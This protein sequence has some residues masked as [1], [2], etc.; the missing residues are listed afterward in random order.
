MAYEEYLSLPD[1]GHLVEWVDGEV[2]FHTPPTPIHQSIILFLSKLLGSYVDQMGIGTIYLAP[3]EV[4]L[5]AGGPSREPDIF[6]LAP[7][8]PPKWE[9]VDSTARPI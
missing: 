4:K 8:K 5:W 3:L 2:L 6:S 9:K 1:D 7:K